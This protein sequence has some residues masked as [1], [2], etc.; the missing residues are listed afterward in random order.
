MGFD[1]PVSNGN[2]LV[3]F[4]QHYNIRDIYYPHVG[5]ANHSHGCISRTGIWGDGQFSWLNASGWVKRMEYMPDTL[6]TSVVATHE[7]LML[8]VV[9]NDLVDFHRDVFLPLGSEQ[10]VARL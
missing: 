1:L 3:S 7:K 2:L 6:A 10:M 4:D 9:F 5:K 8:K